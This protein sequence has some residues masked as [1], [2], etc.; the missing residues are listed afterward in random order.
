MAGCARRRFH[1]DAR[2]GIRSVGPAEP[3]RVF[4]HGGD[5]RRIVEQ[6]PQLMVEDGDLRAFDRRSGLEQHVRIALLLSADRD[7]G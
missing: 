4:A 1:D 2:D 6:P 5:A 3:A 7:R